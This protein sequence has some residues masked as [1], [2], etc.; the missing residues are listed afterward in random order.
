ML[1]KRSFIADD[2][3]PKII[4]KDERGTKQYFKPFPQQKAVLDAWLAG[5]TRILLRCG[6]RGAKTFTATL[7]ATVECSM[8]PS[9]ALPLRLISHTGPQEEVTDRV[10][11]YLHKWLYTDNLFGVRPKAYKR[12]R[13]LI[14]PWGVQTQGKSTKRDGGEPD[15][16]LGDGIV[17]RVADEH[18]RDKPDIL[19]QYLLPPLWDTGGWIIIPSTPQ[20][21]LNHMYHTEQDWQAQMDAGDPRYY[22]AHW[23]SY[24]NPHI[25]R[26]EI[27][28]YVAALE[29][30]GKHKL[31]EQ[32]VYAEYTAMDKAIYQDFRPTRLNSDGNDI[33]WHVDRVEYDPALPIH[34]G[35]DW[36]TAHN[37]CVY[38]GH[39]YHHNGEPQLKIFKEISKA[40]LNPLDQLYAIERFIRPD[41]MHEI[42]MCYC[43]PS[44]LGNK[45]ILR[46]NGLPV[47]EA[48]KDAKV[49]LNS[50]EEGILEVASAFSR[51]DFPGIVI[52]KS[53][54]SL[55][56]GLQSYHRD[57]KNGRPVKLNDD[58]VDALRYLFMGCVGL[59]T[60]VPTFFDY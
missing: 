59:R 39:V 22:V 1:I 44:G 10:F 28:D 18:A 15:D 57:D 13:R 42:E 47:Y 4:V 32:E 16:L 53:C 8:R 20:G 41:R 31:I 24:D 9:G 55:I 25:P 51:V 14:L 56:K 17:G 2:L 37:F 26:Q 19:H 54:Q 48:T 40:G 43:D 45:M 21:K 49:R 5:A 29:R 38:F 27:D 33:P 30:Q 7:P 46:D 35:I 50:V 23:T 11:N 12:E 52:D 34:L 60:A 6:R 36:G 3:W 58:E